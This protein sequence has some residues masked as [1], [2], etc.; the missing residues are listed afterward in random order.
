MAPVFQ[1]IADLDGALSALLEEET[2]RKRNSGMRAKSETGKDHGVLGLFKK[3]ACASCRSGV[4]DS[5]TMHQ[6]TTMIRRT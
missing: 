2:R 4:W 6:D 3:G 1:T 5:L